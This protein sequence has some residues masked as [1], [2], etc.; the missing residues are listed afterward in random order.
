MKKV[1]H[2]NGFFPNTIVSQELQLSNYKA[3]NLSLPVR[4]DIPNYT[5]QSFNLNVVYDDKILA[6]AFVRKG[7]L[8]F[9]LINNFRLNSKWAII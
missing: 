6:L 7:T 2:L 5:S 1:W 8:L 4:Q 9:S 3:N